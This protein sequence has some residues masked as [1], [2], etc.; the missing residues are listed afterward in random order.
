MIEILRR[1]IDR[2]NRDSVKRIYN[3]AKRAVLFVWRMVGTVDSSLILSMYFVLMGI[4]LL[5]LNVRYLDQITVLNVWSDSVDV[6]LLM[7][8]AFVILGW[9][10]AYTRSLVLLTLGSLVAIVYGISAIAGVRSDLLSFEGLMIFAQN[11][12]FAL[13]ILR[14]SYVEIQ[15]VEDKR[16]YERALAGVKAYA[17]VNRGRAVTNSTRE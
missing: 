9:M 6:R 7:A 3:G 16:T 15:R 14:T 5:L 13:A 10:I 17:E 2:T 4:V 8:V 1:G 12:P 11:V